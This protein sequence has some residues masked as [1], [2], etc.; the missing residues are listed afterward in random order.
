[1]D[2]EVLMNTDTGAQAGV[3]AEQMTVEQLVDKLRDDGFGIG[4]WLGEWQPYGGGFE[5]RGDTVKYY[6][7]VYRPDRFSE[8]ND[9]DGAGEP[10]GEGRDESLFDAIREAGLQALKWADSYEWSSSEDGDQ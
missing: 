10:I 3:T 9:W 4:A 7:E 5:H 6:V 1:M 8:D 2:V